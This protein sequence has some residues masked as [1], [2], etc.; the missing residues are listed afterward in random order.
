MTWSF[1]RKVLGGVGV[2]A[3]VAAV[4]SVITWDIDD[5]PAWLEALATTAALI[6]AV[7]AARYAFAAFQ[8]ETR[9]EERWMDQQRS[10][11]AELI[12]AWPLVVSFET[13]EPDPY[14][15][16]QEP[17]GI[18]GVQIQL[19]NASSTPVTNVWI[20]VAIVVQRLDGP[21][22]LQM[23]G[24]RIA[25]VLPPTA[26]K[27]EWIPAEDGKRIDPW[28]HVP[29]GSEPEYWCELSVSFRD[30]GGRDWER[31]PDGQLLLVQ[32]ANAHEYRNDGGKPAKG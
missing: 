27:E 6:A 21:R 24:L 22:R 14:S 26:G 20:D 28:E 10:H 17:R 3:V 1:E 9:R 7:F 5:Y 12:S 16:E 32:D 19:Q 29:A 15:S 4:G 8:L 23:T 13:G 2:V 18:S 31:I 11:Q 25:R 30:A